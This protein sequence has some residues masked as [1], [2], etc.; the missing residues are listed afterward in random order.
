MRREGD[1]GEGVGGKKDVMVEVIPP[2]VL[3]VVGRLRTVGDPT[4][5]RGCSRGAWYEGAT[6]NGSNIFE[7]NDV[8]ANINR[9]NVP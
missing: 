8:M 1:F 9:E 7:V 5:T 4:K 3:G 2:G 6:R